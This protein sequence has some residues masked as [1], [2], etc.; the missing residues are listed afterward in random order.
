MDVFRQ[1]KYSYYMFKAQRPPE[2]EERIYETG[3]MVY[4]A[5]EMTPFSP[6]DVTVYSNCDEVRL[7]YNKG[8]NT[9]TYTKPTNGEGMPSPIITFKDVYDFMIDKNMSMKERKQDE[10]FLLAEGLVDGEVVATHEV[11]PARR[12]EK[13]LLWVDDEGTGLKADGSDIVTV[14]AAIADK[15]GNIKR[16]N[17]YYVSFQIEGE[18]RIVGGSDVLA[19]PA[20]VKWGTAPVL[21]QSTLNPG[22][23]KVTASVLFEGSQMPSS[24]VLEMESQSAAHP[25]IY[26]AAEA[27][28][29][30]ANNAPSL[31]RKMAKSA[32]ELEQ[33]QLLKEQNSQ[34]LK[35]VE[36][37]QADFG[38]K[39]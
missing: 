25:M 30:P 36:L 34:R 17:N 9:W 4:I 33:E 10:V 8:G 14:V 32:A 2:K 15:N 19:N 31:G 11:R 18:G 29:I 13:I 37:Q 21:I 24:A 12:P 27:S 16:L 39:K 20:P 23:M 7:T 5:H 22:K 28:L 1:P 35:E 26:D 6:K 38:E 3:P